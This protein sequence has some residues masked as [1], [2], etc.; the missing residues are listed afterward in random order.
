MIA[1]AMIATFTHRTLLLLCAIFITLTGCAKHKQA[2]VSVPSPKRGFQAPV[3][4][5]RIGDKEKGEASWY[6]EP[7]N[8]RRAASGEIFDME[9]LTAAHRTLPF[10]TWVEVTNLDNGKQVDVRITDR[11]PFVD[12]RIIDLSRGAAREI[13]LL[14][15]GIA[16]VE[17]KVIEAPKMI[18]RNNE[19]F[20]L[21]TSPS[22]LSS[23]PSEPRPTPSGEFVVQAGAFASRDRAEALASSLLIVGEARVVASEA[24][25]PLWRVWVGENLTLDLAQKLAEEVKALTG[26]SVVVRGR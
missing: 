24:T 15:T 2:R 16:K 21:P 13:D 14:R 10:Q 11:G 20:T 17:L 4:P 8:G 12:G 18:S 6:G 19:P 23:S 22:D 9:Q 26:Q 25:P 7:Y 1:N 5:A 3:E